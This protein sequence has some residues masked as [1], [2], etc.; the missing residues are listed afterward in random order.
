M[1][2]NRI[3]V[4]SLALA[5]LLPSA[6]STGVG[7]HGQKTDHFDPRFLAKS[8]IDRVV[9]TNRAEIMASL[10]RVAD[11]LYKRNPKEWKKSGQPGI[12]AALK[13]LFSG[14]V[15]FPEL[16]GKREGAAVLLAFNASY[17]GDRVLAVMAGLL[18][19]TYAAFENKDDFYMLDS[20]DEQKLYNCARNIEIAIWKL[21]SS[22][23]LNSDGVNE[24][25]LLSNEIDPNAPNLS[26]EREFGRVIGLLDFLSRVVA[27]KQGRTITR[28]T[29]SVATAVFFPIGAL[30]F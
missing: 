2:S 17:Q 8:D 15:D 29:Q 4:L 1:A 13:R 5:A 12:D 6:C 30:K 11:K 26:F 25:V 24:L 27:D 7:P 19:M 9:D 14:R 18:G 22:K 23:M 3:A 10:R 16:D 20:L 21:S 28:F